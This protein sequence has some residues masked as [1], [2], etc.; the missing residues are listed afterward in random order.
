MVG[1]VGVVVSY[2]SS[3][4]P[5]PPF[6]PLPDH[7]ATQLVK[8][9]TGKNLLQVVDFDTFFSKSSVIFYVPY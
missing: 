9:M 1:V 3:P 6:N 4:P 2:L 7:A 8:S 5:P